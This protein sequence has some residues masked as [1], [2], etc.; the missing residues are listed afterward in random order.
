VPRATSAL[1]TLQR[2]G[3]SIGTALLAVVLQHQTS[4]AIGA[5]GSGAGAELQ[6]LPPGVRSHFAAPLASAFGHTFLWAFAISL[7]AAV[8]A[9]LLARADRSGR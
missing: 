3:G 8:P 9:L 6:Q 4:A 2:V 1:N 5:G 7:V